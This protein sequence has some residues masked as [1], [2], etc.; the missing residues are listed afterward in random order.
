MKRFRLLVP[1]VF[2]AASLAQEANQGTI[3]GFVY[4][5]S[6]AVVGSAEIR[7][8]SQATG[9]TRETRTGGD[10]V[11]TVVALQPGAY[12]VRASAKGFKNAEAKD[13]QLSVGASLRLNFNLEVG[14]VSDTITVTDVAAALK[15]ESGEV[16]SLVTG[17]QVTEIPI[18][19]RN[20]TQFL[21]LGTGVV[22]AQTGRQMGLGQEG[23][24]LMAVHGGRISMNKYTY[25]GTL[26]MDTGGNRGLD[27]FPPMEAIGEVKVQKSNY[28]ADAGGFGYG[29]V[30]IVTKS[31]TQQ[32]HGDRLLPQTQ[33]ARRTQPPLR[34][35]QRR[36][37]LHPHQSRLR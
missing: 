28:G 2:A 5:Q 24:P 26:A 16:S 15:T 32:Y 21:S 37:R 35:H 20:F 3:T 36:L 25:D 6:Q 18:N 9:Q 30:N 33:N 34:P 22:S 17:T 19:G 14:A 29:I 27:L 31:G 4:D 12:T 8:I 23:N 11:Y 7:V 13:V 1:Y 10:G